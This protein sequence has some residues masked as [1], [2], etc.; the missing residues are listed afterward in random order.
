[1]LTCSWA[2]EQF[3]KKVR[4]VSKNINNL[5]FSLLW[6]LTIFSETIILFFSS[7]FFSAA[8]KDSIEEF[9]NGHL[10]HV[11]NQNLMR[12]FKLVFYIPKLNTCTV[13]ICSVF[14]SICSVYKNTNNLLGYFISI[15][16]HFQCDAYSYFGSR[17]FQCG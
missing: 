6:F 11:Q 4:S 10:L 16:Y 17:I 12:S 5:K 2:T 3:S 13:C 15:P 14:Q 7:R 8:K 1:M 9:K